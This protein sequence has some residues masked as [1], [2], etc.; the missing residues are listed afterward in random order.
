MPHSY[1]AVC[2]GVSRFEQQ[3]MGRGPKDIRA[4]LIGDLLVVRLQGVLTAALMATRGWA[5]PE[6]KAVFAMRGGYGAPHLL[7]LI[8]YDLIRKNP[9]IFLGYSDITALHLAIN[10]H[11][12]LVTLHGPNVLSDYTEY[13]RKWFRPAIFGRKPLGVL[14]NP[15]DTDPI[16]PRHFI[17]T[18]RPGKAEG[19]V[20][21]G[22][23]TLIS[24]LMGTPY[25]P[26]F[27]GKIVLL[28]DIGEE[29]YRIDRMLNQLRLAGVFR[30]AAGVIIGECVDCR[31]SD[32]K[33]S[34]G[35]NFSLGEVIDAMLGTL[36]IPVFYGLTFGHTDDQLTIPLGLRAIMDADNG[37]LEFLES[38][39]I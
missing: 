19:E 20:I 32:F 4:H 16:K 28:E 26:Q 5:D 24:T 21:G 31:P 27:K 1:G 7:D 15:P 3:Y 23:L 37:T 12:R 33:P 11:A 2:A 29:P 39:C 14:S 36:P 25:Q 18:I 6:V 35:S 38:A 13:T 30:E 34:L 10:R 9:K 22:N 17:R 8:D